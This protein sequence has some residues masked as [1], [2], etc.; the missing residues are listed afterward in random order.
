ML[1]YRFF[2]RRLTFCLEIAGSFDECLN[3]A[4]EKGWERKLPLIRSLSDI[5]LIECHRIWFSQ[6]QETKGIHE[7]GA[8]QLG[9]CRLA[10]ATFPCASVLLLFL[11]YCGLVPPGAWQPWPGASLAVRGQP[12]RC[13]PPDVSAHVCNVCLFLC[14]MSLLGLA[15][16]EPLS[17]PAASSGRKAA[18]R[19]PA[20]NT[21]C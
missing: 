3:V 19:L 5:F 15:G 13:S 4:N 11:L 18:K 9:A 16:N 12:S 2:I 7:A 21:V 10:L 20:E 8:V 1:I 14:F 6:K 17:W